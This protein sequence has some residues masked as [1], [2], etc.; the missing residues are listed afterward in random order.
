MPTR[1]FNAY[2]EKVVVYAGETFN[3]FATTAEVQNG[4]VSIQ[5]S[6][7]PLSTTT[8]YQL[9]S[10]NPTCP[11][12]VPGSAAAPNAY[13]FTCTPADPDVTTQT[14]IIAR[15]YV[16]NFCSDVQVVAGDHFIWHNTTSLSATIAPSTGNANNWPLAQTDYDV[17]P[18]DWVEVKIPADAQPGEYTLNVTY[19]DGSTPCDTKATQPKI[20]VSG[21]PLP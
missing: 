3:W 17:A 10:S 18:G 16:T 7:W 14:L 15:Q 12:S 2:S 20:S 11:A 8:P 6:S 4:A 13:T 1:Q 5:S 9:T 19:S 21:G